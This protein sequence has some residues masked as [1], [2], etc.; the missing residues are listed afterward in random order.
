MSRAGVPL[1]AIVALMICNLIAGCG[2][3][4]GDPQLMQNTRVQLMDWHI[5]GFWVI[6][7]PVAWIRVTNYNQVPIK[8]IIV[9]YNTMDTAGNPLDQGTY[10]M[11]GAVAPGQTKNF[12]E[13]YLGLTS[14]Y[15]DRLSIKLLSVQRE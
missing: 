14:L 4:Q 6:N 12:I 1:L 8:D 10:T 13:L 9:Q 5:S 11:E 15:T 3:P 2:V 7:C